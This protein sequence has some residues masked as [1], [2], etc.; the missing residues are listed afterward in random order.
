MIHEYKN[1]LLLRRHKIKLFFIFWKF[2]V[3][4][5]GCLLILT[6]MVLF[7]GYSWLGN[8]FDEYLF[9]LLFSFVNFAALALILDIIAHFNNL[10]YINDT[11]IYIIQNWL[12]IKEDIEIIELS[13]VTKVNIVCQWFLPNICSFWKIV[14]EQ[15]RTETRPL[16]FIPEPYRVMSNIRAKMEKIK[17]LWWAKNELTSSKFDD[18]KIFWKI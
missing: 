13:Q 15:Q 17:S 11:H 8:V 1:S 12:F 16:F 4:L 2:L 6:I 18:S 7:A 9:I 14:I 10:I 5:V 3:Y